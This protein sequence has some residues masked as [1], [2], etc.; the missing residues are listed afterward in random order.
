MVGREAIGERGMKLA[1][2][3]LSLWLA[4]IVVQANGGIGHAI[5]TVSLPT[6]NTP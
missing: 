2:I 1:A 6:V 3:I 5:A 4:A